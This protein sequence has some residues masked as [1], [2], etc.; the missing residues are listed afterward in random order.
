MFIIEHLNFKI[1]IGVYFVTNI[2]IQIF[3]LFICV[4][5]FI[6]AVLVC[7]ITKLK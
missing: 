7:T 2:N 6:I 4:L 3:I 1:N 5:S